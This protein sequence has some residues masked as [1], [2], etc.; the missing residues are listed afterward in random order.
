[1]KSTSVFV[2]LLSKITTPAVPMAALSPTVLTRSPFKKQKN[3][4]YKGGSSTHF[5]NVPDI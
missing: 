1:M 2:S 4:A 5:Q 3:T